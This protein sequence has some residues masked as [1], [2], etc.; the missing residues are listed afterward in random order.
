MGTLIS[1]FYGKGAGIRLDHWS[2]LQTGCR[3]RNAACAVGESCLPDVLPPANEPLDICVPNC[4]GDLNCPPNYFCLR[5]VSGE[6]FPAVCIPGIP[7]FRCITDMDCIIGRCLDTGDGFKLCATTC[8]SND[9]CARFGDVRGAFMCAVDPAGKGKFCQ[10]W[11]AFTGAPCGADSGCRAHEVCIALSPY[12]NQR[13]SLGEC[14]ARCSAEQPCADR[15]G[16]PHVCIDLAGR[17]SCYPGAV[18]LPC[19][20]DA[21]CFGEL[22]CLDVTAPDEKDQLVRR[23]RCSA[24]CQTDDDCA[25]NRFAGKITYC[26]EGACAAR[27]HRGF[28]CERDIECL[29][30]GCK[31]STNAEEAMRGVKRCP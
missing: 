29:L 28:R 9:D 12:F 5:K 14:R 6:G 2:C 10:N 22:K 7:G 30:D 31:P 25:A 3:A 18:H 23:R 20:S 27:F 1:S 21:D 11:R 24:P 13:M 17:Q 19:E 8:A 4:D 16:V 15:A 26:R